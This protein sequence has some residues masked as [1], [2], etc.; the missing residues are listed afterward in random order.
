MK[1]SK[2]NFAEWCLTTE[3]YIFDSNLKK[4]FDRTTLKEVSWSKILEIYEK[5]KR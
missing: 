1:T 2:I 3:E 4:W 5:Q